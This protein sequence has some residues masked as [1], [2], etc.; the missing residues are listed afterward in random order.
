MKIS[1]AALSL[2]ALAGFSNAQYFSAGWSPGQ[3]VPAAEPEAAT[4]VPG[5]SPLPKPTGTAAGEAAAPSQATP[6]SFASLLDINKLLTTEPAVNLFKSFGIN[7]TERVQTVLS[8]KIWDERVE[9]ITDDNYQDLIVNEPLTTQE[10]KDR[11]WVIVMSVLCV[12]GYASYSCLMKFSSVTSAKQEGV[13][14]Y[15]DQ[16]FDAAYNESQIA[17]DLPHVRWGRID[18]LN[19]TALTT[20]WGVWQYV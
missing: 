20:K 13:S 6:F 14:K 2:L 4:F 8:Q 17:G 3:K 10:E 11:L 9:L 7:I 1:A 19:V 18:Y 5:Q 12:S 16:V 15:M